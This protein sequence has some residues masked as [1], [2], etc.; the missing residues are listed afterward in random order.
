MQIIQKTILIGFTIICMLPACKETQLANTEIETLSDN[1]PELSF[2]NINTLYTEDTRSVLRMKAPVQYRYQN[3]NERYP[4]GINIEMY[5]EKGELRSTLVADSAIYTDST[6][7]YTVMGNVVVEG[8]HDGKKLETELLNWNKITEEIF[9]DD[10]VTITE[11]RQILTGKGLKANQDFSDYT[12]L[13]PTG[14]AYV[15]D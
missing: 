5:T 14:V 1:E 11:G 7:L 15:E 8:L 3:G 6:N 4:K 2:K 13:E 10:S 9:T 12:I